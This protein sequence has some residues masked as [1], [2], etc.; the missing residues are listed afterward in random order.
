MTRH[1]FR[2]FGRSSSRR[3]QTACRTPRVLAAAA[4]LALAGASFAQ[5]TGS[6]PGFDLS[7]SSQAGGGGKS[8]G[9][10]FSLEGTMGQ[11]AAAP[12]GGG[13]F[14]VRTGFGA[15]C[16]PDCEIGD[17]DCDGSVNGSDLGIMLLDFGPCA[18]PYYC[19]SDLDGN[20]EIDAGDIALMLLIWH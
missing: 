11:T 9:G 4:L 1:L 12:M 6:S 18:T 17:L 20:G 14:S 3:H 7:A 2:E 15:T 10:V 8:T 5:V 16:P 19:P 13:D